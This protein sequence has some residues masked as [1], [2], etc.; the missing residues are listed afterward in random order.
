MPNAEQSSST[1]AEVKFMRLQSLSS[2][3]GVPNIEMNRSYKISHDSFCLLIFGDKCHRVSCEMICDN[4]DILD[5]WWLIQLHCCLY[6]GEVY[7]NQF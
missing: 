6:A 2:L 3:V 1:N 4:Q 7:M 5:A